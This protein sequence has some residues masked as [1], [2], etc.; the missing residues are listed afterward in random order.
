MDTLMRQI[1]DVGIIAG[2]LLGILWI[3]VAYVP[4]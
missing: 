1:I 4:H 3:A 2:L